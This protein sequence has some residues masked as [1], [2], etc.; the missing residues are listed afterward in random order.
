MFRVLVNLSEASEQEWL[1]ARKTGIGASE[2]AAACG[3]SRWKTPLALYLEKTDPEVHTIDNEF[4]WWGRQLEPLIRH[5][6]PHSYTEATGEEILAEEWPM[7]LQHVDNPWMLYTPDGSVKIPTGGDEDEWDAGLLELKTTTGLHRDEWADGN[8][9]L[10]YYYQCQHGMAVT[11]MHWAMLVVLIDKQMHWVRVTRNTPFIEEM[12][13]VEADF[14]KRVQTGSPPE[15]AIGDGHLMHHLYPES[16]DAVVELPDLEDTAARYLELNADIK[17]LEGERELV[18]L[19]IQQAMKDHKMG[20]LGQHK[21]SWPRW[22]RN[23]FDQ[24]KFR[25]DHPDL[26]GQYIKQISTGRFTLK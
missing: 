6:F 12:M 10:E 7:L 23:S 17:R 25:A 11:D 18:K 8:V 26:Y 3:A 5:R 14:W 13:Q 22:S 19:R 1:K 4:M 24:K 20:Q 16:R 9:P 15:G 21:V 2:A